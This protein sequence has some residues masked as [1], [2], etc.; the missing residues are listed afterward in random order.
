MMAAMIG[1]CGWQWVAP[2]WMAWAVVYGQDAEPGV[3]VPPPVVDALM[4]VPA[5]ELGYG[6]EGSLQP[7][8]P[9]ELTIINLGGG[10]ILGNAEDGVRYEGPGVQIT[11]DTGLELFADQLFWNPKEKTVVMEG[12][13]SVYQGDTLQRGERVVYQYETKFLD[14]K[15]L[16]ASADPFLLEA[17]KFTMESLRGRNVFVGY[18]AKVTT[19]DS[20]NPDYWIKAD[21]TTIHPGEKVVFDN[22]KIYAGDTPV[23]WFPY[24][25]Q[26][27]D[28]N[29]GYHFIPGGKSNWGAFL[30]NRYGVMLGG[31]ADPATG[32][33]NDAWL[34]SQWRLDL[35]AR[36]GAGVGLD[37]T[38]TR[39]EKEDSFPGLSLYYINDLDPSVS[40]SGVPR[41]FVNEDRYRIGLEHRHRFEIPEDADWR[42]DF[43]LSWL[44]DRH[45]L[46]D[47]RTQEYRV[48]PQPD[49]VIGLYRRDDA[50]LWSL[51][52]RIR[53]NDYYRTDTRLPELAYDRARA[54]VFGMPIEHEGSTT[55]SFLGER[56]G[57][58]TQSAILN[59]L[60]G[61][62][63]GNPLAPRLLQQLGGYERRLAEQMIALPIGDPRREAIRVQLEDSQFGRFQTYQEWSLPMMLGGVVSVVPQAGAG[64]SNYVAVDGPQQDLDRFHLHGGVE[65]SVKF[66]KDLGPV[67]S[68]ALGL[69]GL[70]HVVQPYGFWSVVSTDD[71]EPGEPAV[72]RLTPTT[73]PR[74]LDPARFTA[75]DEMN[76]WNV[77]RAGTRHRLY[78]KRDGQSYE[79]LFLD[80]YFDTF[81]NDPES[82]RD[83]SNLYNDIRWQPLPWAA[84]EFET[85]FPIAD[86]GSGF[87]E[88]ATRLHVMPTDWF[89]MALGYR[90]LNG[91]PILIDSNRFDLQTFL[92]VSENWGFGMRHIVELD[93]NTLEGQEYMLHRDLGSWVAGIGVSFRD[94]R[95]E[96]EFGVVLS[97]TLKEFPGVSLPFQMDAP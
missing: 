55:F 5:P 40:R 80:T 1:R 33:G 58:P 76:S 23:F 6:L 9:K 26:P 46:E 70:L 67:R 73:R 68:R 10:A 78:T 71:F 20:E 85:Q 48:D 3:P 50:S 30:L 38:D 13:V 61:M 11:T 21:K 62:T 57:D 81:L 43:Q 35:M 32:E 95:L 22:M 66:T 29:L 31:E 77:F 19:D 18:E 56:T 96:E 49:N 53:L 83:F 44:S 39:L 2:V 64:Y 34:L 47:F 82:T 91:H 69:D 17:G 94:N 51:F 37:L 97:L 60:Q 54:P 28:S 41:G 86:G 42:M 93:D 27:L 84:V 8:M 88:Y 65:T 63:T 14:T 72:D 90:M 45:Y 75:T 24:L 15:G 89:E 92:R 52:G 59:P 12:K 87:R 36:R 4:P 79:W 25:S 74:P 7:V 16:R